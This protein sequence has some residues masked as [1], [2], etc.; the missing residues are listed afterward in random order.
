[1]RQPKRNEALANFIQELVYAPI[2]RAVEVHAPIKK[3]E[4]M[5]LM[6]CRDCVFCETDYC[7]ELDCNLGGQGQYIYVI[8]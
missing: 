1:M 5:P 3:V 8:A 7:K 2:G 4:L 6:S